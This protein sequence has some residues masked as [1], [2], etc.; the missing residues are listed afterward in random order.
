MDY[1]T[2]TLAIEDG[3]AVLTLNRPDKMNAMSRQ[4]RAEITHAMGQVAQ[5]ARAV[6]LTGAGTA[7]CSGQ[8]LGDA[9]GGAPDL[10]RVLR[11]EYGPMLRAIND[12]PVPTLAAVN[13]PAAGAGASLAL[14]T[15]VVIASERAYFLQAFTRIGLIPDAGGTWVLPR[16]MGLAKAMGAALFADRI[17]ARQAEAWGMIWEAVPEEDFDAHWRKRA[18]Y[19]AEGP[20]VA[21]GAVKTALRGSFDQSLEDQLA[22]EAHL[23]GKCGRT[24]D[25]QEGVVAFSEKRVAKFEG[26]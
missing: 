1:Q 18:T 24:R 10:E 6:V 12:C 16:Q 11:D 25:F 5:Q 19:L 3:L 15:D 17:P 20:T 21:F 9:G 13:G 7:F 22:I 26:R 4:M 23:Q 14:A 8:D 2:I